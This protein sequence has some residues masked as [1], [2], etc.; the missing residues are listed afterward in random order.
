[1]YGI[2]I[3]MRSQMKKFVLTL[4]YEKIHYIRIFEHLETMF[5]NY[6]NVRSKTMF[7]M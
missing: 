5:Y 2:H 4:N 6:I 3:E 7:A 1:L